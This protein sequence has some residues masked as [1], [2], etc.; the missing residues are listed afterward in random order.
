MTAGRGAGRRLVL[1]AP[2][3]ALALTAGC[4]VLPQPAYIER[5]E[6][7][8]TLRRT[9]ALPPRA[10]GAV[11]TVRA[12]TAGPGV[13]RR[14]VAWLRPDGSLHTDFYNQWAV[15]PAEGVTED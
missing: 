7:P 8:L 5:R 13:E 2:I 10:G 12:L 14:G 11:L 3:P 6:W 15:P 9:A 4:S 1:L